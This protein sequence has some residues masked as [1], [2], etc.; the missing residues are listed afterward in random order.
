DN[1]TVYGMA[2]AYTFVRALQLAGRNPTRQS[3]V[4]ALNSGA[5]NSGGPGLSPLDYS[6]RD[7]GGYG[8]ERVGVVKDGGIVL[9]GPVYHARD[10]GPIQ[11]RTVGATSPPT[12]F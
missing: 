3:I 1:M 12:S 7:H 11:Q 10:A 5:A 9:G 4:A 8:G 2:A 6:P